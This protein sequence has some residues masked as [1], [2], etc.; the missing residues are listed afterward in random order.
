MRYV[1]LFF[2]AFSA[3][4]NLMVEVHYRIGSRNCILRYIITN[5]RLARRGY[6][7]IRVPNGTH[8]GVRGRIFN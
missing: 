4:Y 2:S 3:W 8:G 5:E 1:S 7:D 6:Y